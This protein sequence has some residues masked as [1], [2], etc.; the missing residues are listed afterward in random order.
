ARLK[1]DYLK[2]EAVEGKL[3][4]K[5]DIAMLEQISRLDGCYV[6]KTDLPKKVAS[7]QT[8]HDR[9]KDLSKVEQAF[10]TSKTAILEMR[11]WFVWTEESTRGHAFVVMLAYLIANHLQK[12]WQALDL[13]VEEALNQLSTLCSMHI[14]FSNGSSY[15]RIPTPRPASALLLA[16][17]G[18]SLPN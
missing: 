12:A 9:Y 4:L 7:S 3:S 6:I 15:H 1:L 14:R 11:P 8:V 2:V 13:T 5:E 16:A 17:A 10:R 18:I